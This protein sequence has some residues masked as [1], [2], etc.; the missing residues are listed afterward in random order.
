MTT[1][2]IKRRSL[3][4]YKTA[5]EAVDGAETLGNVAFARDDRFLTCT[6]SYVDAVVGGGYP[7]AILRK[8]K[9]EIIWDWHN[10]TVSPKPPRRSYR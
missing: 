8:Y 4:G 5:E 7:I 9:G 6:Q 2:E 1:Q 10:A 3:T